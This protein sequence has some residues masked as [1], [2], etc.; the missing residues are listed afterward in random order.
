MQKEFKDYILFTYGNSGAGRSY[1][2]GINI[3]DT[4]FRFMPIDVFG[5]QGRSLYEINNLGL[6]LKIDRFVK[7][8]SKKA[9]KNQENIFQQ[10][11]DSTQSSYGSR[12]FCSA[13]MT[14]LVNYAALHTKLNDADEIVRSTQK[15]STISLRLRKH[16][17]LTDIDKKGTDKEV[18]AKVRVGQYY[19]RKMMLDNYNNKCCITG[20]DMPVFLQACHISGWEED[21]NNRLNPENGLL[22]NSTYHLAFDNH[23]IAFD[24]D[25]RMIVSKEIKDHFAANI[26]KDMFYKYEGV[27]MSHPLYFT[28]SKELLSKHRKLFIG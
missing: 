16:F 11:G 28:P 22:L 13:A 2:Q 19:F 18:M 24:D 23:L 12:G 26:V 5:L 21:A 1:I 3:L 15:G 25:L 17:K 4:I 8:E 20:M 10:Y 27:Q 7:D 9:R 6:L 14:Q